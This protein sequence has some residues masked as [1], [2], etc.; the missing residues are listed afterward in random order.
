M[1]KATLLALMLAGSFYAGTRFNVT[2]TPR[3]EAPK[4]SVKQQAKPSPAKERA[5]SRSVPAAVG[6]PADWHE[7]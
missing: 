5:K 7:I 2:V 3:E 1:L 4:A 6:T